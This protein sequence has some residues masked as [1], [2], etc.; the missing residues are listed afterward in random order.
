MGG[1]K[2]T[3]GTV[4]EAVKEFIGENDATLDSISVNLIREKIFTDKK[5]FTVELFKK[6]RSPENKSFTMEEK[7]I[8]MAKSILD[9]LMSLMKFINYQ[10]TVH[11]E[12]DL[13]IL[14]IS[15]QNKDGLLIGKNGQNLLAIQYLLSIILDRRLKRHVPVIVDVDAYREK[16]VAYL[17]N[18][19]KTLAEK[20]KETN[21]EVI[22]DFLPSYERKL[23][24]EEITGF[25]S[26]KTFSIISGA[27]TFSICLYPFNFP[28]HTVGMP[29]GVVKSELL[30]IC[31]S[32][33]S[34]CIS[35]IPCTPV[36][37]TYFFSRLLN[38]CRNVFN[39]IS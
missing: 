24:H 8:E 5:E 2:K 9:K 32:L 17:K 30:L 26:L 37:T 38:Q 39:K 20:A 16:R 29:S 35:M 11:R 3:A 12:N 34:F 14:R 18:L 22:T 6:H 10:I 1:V 25:D 28:I 33:K 21:S 4:S 36:K 13:V 15:T 19:C 23:I 7:D 27:Y 31:F